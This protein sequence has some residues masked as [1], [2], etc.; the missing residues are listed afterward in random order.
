MVFD[1][2]K[3]VAWFPEDYLYRING[4]KYYCVGIEPLRDVIFGAI[5]MKNYD[6][7]FNK[8]KRSVSF[9]RA[10]CSLTRDELPFIT[11]GNL[12]RRRRFM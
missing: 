9:T 4:T 10:N 7:L 11:T 1:Q 2:G 3:T 6:V 12:I 8:D 5:F